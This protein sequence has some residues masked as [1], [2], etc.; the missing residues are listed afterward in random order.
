MMIHKIH[1]MLGI[2]QQGDCNWSGVYTTGKFDALG[3]YNVGLLEV[4]ISLYPS[5]PDGYTTLFTIG[6]IDDGLWQAF[7][8]KNDYTRE[9]AIE[10]INKLATEFIAFLGG[11]TKLPT[12]KD[13]NEFL[14]KH[15]LWG[16]YQG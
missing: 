9:E 16:E 4:R 5:G 2:T 7:D 3:D 15:S 1:K 8:V 13:L 10:R 6:T 14:M 11:S 12:E